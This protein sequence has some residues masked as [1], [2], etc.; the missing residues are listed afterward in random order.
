[1]TNLGEAEFFFLPYFVNFLEGF[2]QF[3][4]GQTLSGIIG[5]IIQV[6]NKVIS[7]LPVSISQPCFHNA[8]ICRLEAPDKADGGETM[9]SKQGCVVNFVPLPK[10]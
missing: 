4:Q 2:F 8:N 10:R 1:M 9:N 6:P 5:V 7:R 3:S